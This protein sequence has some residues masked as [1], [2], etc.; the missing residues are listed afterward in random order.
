MKIETVSASYKETRSIPSEYGNISPEIRITASLEQ[1]ED[2]EQIMQLLSETAKAQVKATLIARFKEITHYPPQDL[3][4][5]N[6]KTDEPDPSEMFDGN[7]YTD[8]FDDYPDPDDQAPDDPEDPDDVD[9]SPADPPENV[10][11]FSVK[12]PQEDDL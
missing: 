9:D 4:D 3:E 12:D 6:D 8:D 7:S 2:P 1:G 11:V 5:P 10:I